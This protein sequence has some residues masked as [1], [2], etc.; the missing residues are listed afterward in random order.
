MLLKTN[1]HDYFEYPSLEA[2]DTLISILT[3]F[4]DL[5]DIDDRSPQSDII[6]LAVAASTK[7]LMVSTEDRLNSALFPKDFISAATAYSV[8]IG[9]IEELLEGSQI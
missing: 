7:A 9:S 4:P 1:F 3:K 5:I 8:K 6:V 2:Q